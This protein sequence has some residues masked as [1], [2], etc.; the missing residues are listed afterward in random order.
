MKASLQV[1]FRDMARS[2]AVEAKIR[3]RVEKLERFS[4]DIISC[5]VVVE[6]S[7]RHH[8]KGNLYHARVDVA[9]PGHELIA[10]RENDINHAHEDIYVAVRDAFDAMRRQLEDYERR[11]RG[12]VRRH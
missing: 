12:E 1:V 3:E 10:N 2:D 6:P 8:H 7:H 5:R 4:D 11:R 9:V